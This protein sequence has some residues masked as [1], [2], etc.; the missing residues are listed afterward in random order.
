[1]VFSSFKPLNKIFELQV[2]TISLVAELYLENL[3]N[4]SIKLDS[5]NVIFHGR[6]PFKEISNWLLSSD[7]LIISLIDKLSFNLTVPAK[8]QAYLGAFKPIFGVI[9]GET[10]SIIN[11]YELGLVSGANDLKSIR[12]N[13]FNFSK[14]NSF[15]NLNSAKKLL[16]ETYDFNVISN[17]VFK[18]IQQ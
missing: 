9:N 2:K 3:K 7:V 18:I 1:M 8:F 17:K 16:H 6:V 15:Y 14:K 11:K 5:K 4:L 13:I 10:N 12:E